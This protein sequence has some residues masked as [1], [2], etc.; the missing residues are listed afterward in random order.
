MT[1]EE[2]RKQIDENNEKILKLTSKIQFVLNR[3]VNALMIQN[4]EL[5]SQCNH[6]FDEEGICIYCD[7]LKED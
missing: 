1:N 5:Q 6:V 3:E 7:A 2:I 4:K